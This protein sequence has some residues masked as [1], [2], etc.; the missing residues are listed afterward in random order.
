ASSRPSTARTGRSAPAG[1]HDLLSAQE[2]SGGRSA[3]RRARDPDREPHRDQRAPRRARRVRVDAT[4]EAEGEGSR[5]SAEQ[6]TVSRV[7]LPPM[8]NE[9]FEV[10]LNGIPQ[11]RD[12][13]FQLEGRT[14]VFPRPLVP[15][16]KLKKFQWVL[17]TIGIGSYTK[18]DSVD[19]VYEH[20]GR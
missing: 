3:G 1:N 17:V 14:L 13:D 9:P 4:E 20:E 7:Q 18:H 2:P 12:L 11:Q 15:E 8:V 5:L 6:A 16:L 19:I 10:Y